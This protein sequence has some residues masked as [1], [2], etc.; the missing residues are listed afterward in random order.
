MKL[1]SYVWLK[2]DGKNIKA[3]YTT[4]TDLRIKLTP[5]DIDKIL[6]VRFLNGTWFTEM[7]FSTDENRL[8][9]EKLYREVV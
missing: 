2:L 3:T 8:D 1:S 5:S 9:F 6:S 4:L 7:E